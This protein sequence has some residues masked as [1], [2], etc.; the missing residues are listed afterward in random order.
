MRVDCFKSPRSAS[1][2][3]AFLSLCLLLA[4]IPLFGNFPTIVAAS[5]DEAPP[6]L[7]DAATRTV[8]EYPK[9]VPA[10]V[11]TDESVVTVEEDGRMIRDDFYAVKVLTREGR[12]EAVARAIYNTDSEKVRDM[13]AWLIGPSGKVKKYGKNET[14]ELALVDNDIYNEA[15]RLVISASGDAEPGAVFGWETI[16]EDRTVF[17]QL[18]WYFQGAALPILRSRL[19]VTLPRGWSADGITLNHSKIEPT[20]NGNTY[21]WELRDMPPVTDEPMSP[22]RTATSPWLGVNLAPPSDKPS[23]TRRAFANW[24][25]VSRWLS[26]ISDSQA[27]IDDALSSKAK[28][29]T[30]ASKTEF[31]KIATLSR[32]VQAVNY[33]SI[34][35]GVGR[36]GGYRPH[37]ATEV[38]AKSYGDCKDKA[39]LMRAMLSAV[40]IKSYLVV[41]YSGDPN[42]VIETWPS[43]HQFNHCIIAVKVSDETQ[44][45]TTINHSTLGRLL[46]FDPTDD[47]TPIGDLPLHEQGSFA[48]IVAGDAGALMKM[49][50]TPP[51]AN[52][53]NRTAEVTLLPSG[54][55][56]AKLHDHASG[57]AAV[58]ERRVFRELS[59]PDY[60]KSIEAWITRGSNGARVSKIAPADD[61]EHGKFSLETEFSAESYGQLMQGRL[62]VFKPAIVS[63]RES[64]ALTEPARKQPVVLRPYAFTENVKIELPPGFD[65]DEMP[66]PAKL[67]T[68]FGSYATKYAVKDGQL[69]FERKLIVRGQT[70]PVSDYARVRSFYEKIRA[71][72]QSPVVLVKK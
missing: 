17:S 44:A 72:E 43:P 25:D 21:A 69:E 50:V 36:G 30:A 48:L 24:T 5:A 1:L 47:N 37:A 14:V 46:I 55:I 49:P 2:K 6:W 29:I 11:L 61:P 16:T 70:I 3:I 13:R 54:G 68:P 34:Q 7:R 38:F 66:D 64:L 12:E 62:L 71:A 32:Y 63:R 28:Q 40:G 26:Q 59:R 60:N 33:V 20:V 8:P 57:Q 67:D 31:E 52:M 19:S 41:I 15:R 58:T 42:R 4:G 56:R 53:L 22:P 45:L 18:E 39:N 9:D 27:A 65:V 35:L 23:V 10:V 51:E